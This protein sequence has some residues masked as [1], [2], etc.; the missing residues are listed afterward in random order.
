MQNKEIPDCRNNS[1]IKYQNRRKMQNRC[2]PNTNTG[3]LTSKGKFD[4]KFT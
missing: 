4:V 1:K 2:I 3:L